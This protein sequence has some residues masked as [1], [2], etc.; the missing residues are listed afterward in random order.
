MKKDKVYTLTPAV[1]ERLFKEKLSPFVKEK[2][3]KYAFEYSAVNKEEYDAAILRIVD[4]LL[5]PDAITAGPHRFE[6]W[7]K[8]WGQNLDELKKEKSV[9]SINPH[10]FGKYPIQ[11]LEQKFIKARSK[12]F[13]RNML[14][15]I[16]YWLFDK[17]MRDAKHIYEFGCGTGHNLLRV[18]E[19][20]K[21]AEIWGL[22]W[23]TSSQGIIEKV[24][25]QKGDKKL[26]GHR[27][28]FFHPDKK[29]VLGND[30]VVYT[31]AALEQVGENYKKFVDYILKNKPKLCVHI[32]PI[33]ELLDEHVLLDYLSIRYF[34]KRKY[35]KGFYLHLKD[36]E[37]AKK[38]KILH[39]QRS[40]IGSYFID[41]YSVIVWKPV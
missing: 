1:F 14:N 38:I 9:D 22:D 40:Y 25:K 18:R 4:I 12:D 39:G 32:E 36:L 33:G 20:N 23:T 6:Q 16:E 31:V 10:Y 21:Q 3:K 5:D 28:D 19:V 17:Y 2:I 8:G 37:K 41:G 29:F 35:L 27:F 11:R 34:E 24:A 13:E 26:F 30:S 7:E 15:I